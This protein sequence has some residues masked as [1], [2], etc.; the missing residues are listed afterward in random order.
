MSR[1]RVVSYNVHACRP[2]SGPTDVEAVAAV[3]RGIEPDVC[4]LQEV[5]HWPLPFRN[6]DQPARLARLT[7]MHGRF[8]ASFGLGRL[9]FGNAL[10]SRN[11]PQAVRRLWLP[12][13][14]EP[15][16]VLHARVPWGGGVHVLTTHLSL[17]A[18]SR[19]KQAGFLVRY[20]RRLEGPLILTGDLNAEPGSPELEILSHFGL[21][22]CGPLD[23]PTFPAEAPARRLDYIAVS[24]H[25]RAG[26]V[27]VPNVH[28]SDHLPMVAD[29]EL[30]SG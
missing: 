14:G 15:R 30:R 17:L 26:E 13:R 29:L 23:T 7:G 8:R 19:L 6:R 5:L 11:R 22:L 16:T 21:V 4:G 3:L 10:L 28:A 24:P 2:T 12:G 9:G 25:W 1:L 27:S 20:L 18:G